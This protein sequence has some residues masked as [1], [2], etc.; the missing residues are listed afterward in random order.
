MAEKLEVIITAEDQASEKLGGI[1]AS[2]GGVLK[3]AGGIGVAA[4]ASK[5]IGAVTDQIGEMVSGAMAAEEIQAQLNNVIESTGGAAGMTAD[6][7]N[8][9]A[10]GLMNVTKFDDDAIVGGQNLLLTFTNIGKDVFPQA[11]ETMLDMSQALGQDM[12]SSAVQ[13]GKA[14]NDPIKGITALSRVGVSFTDAQKEQISAL[15]ESGDVMGAQKIILEELQREFGGSAK[16]AGETFAGKMTI[17]QNKVDNVKEAI[18]AKLIPIISGAVDKMLEWGKVIWDKLQPAFQMIGDKMAEVWAI[19]SP[20]IAM[21]GQLW[22]KHGEKIMTVV[23]NAWN[24]ISSIIG[25]ALEFIWGLIKAVVQLISGDWEGAWNTIKETFSGLWENLKN[26]VGLALEYIKSILSIAWEAIKGVASGAWEGFKSLIGGIWDGITTNIGNTLEGLKGLLSGAW[27]TI[28]SVADNA[29]NGIA[30]IM[31]GIWTGVES[32]FKGGLNAI[33]GLLNGA[34]DFINAIEIKIPEVDIFG[35]KTGG[36]TIG[37][38]DIPKVPYLAAGGIVTGPTLA[39]IGESGPEAVVPLSR[40]G[41]VIDYDKLASALTSALGARTPL[42]VNVT[43]GPIASNVDVE[44]LAYR[45]AQ[46]IQKR[47]R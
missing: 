36:W 1:Q 41:G 16:A 32:A 29:W 18:G 4:L 34:I 19:V 26:I 28:T 46:S 20:I 38:P 21:I 8:E 45:V 31:T 22:E 47:Q 27:N 37:L 25:G 17:L 44:A 14:L 33:I 13:L 3:I 30:G 6:A 10:E 9:L 12:Q 35:W 43:T 15:Q 24:L 11:T 40:G 39:M 2:L 23:Q 7:V 42:A 5:G